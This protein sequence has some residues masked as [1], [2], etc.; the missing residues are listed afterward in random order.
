MIHWNIKIFNN[1]NVIFILRLDK[2]SVYFSI[3]Q[4][5]WNVKNILRITPKIL[6]WIFSSYVL[7][8]IYVKCRMYNKQ[9][10]EEQLL[11]T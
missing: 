11:C 7:T 4:L 6:P 10:A 3:I 1:T 5:T 9:N 8:N 2:T